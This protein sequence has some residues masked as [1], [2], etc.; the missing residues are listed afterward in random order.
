[1]AASGIE[2]DLLR[3]SVGSEPAD[4]IIAVLAEA[5]GE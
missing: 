3:L 5:L 4:E 2:P 1:L